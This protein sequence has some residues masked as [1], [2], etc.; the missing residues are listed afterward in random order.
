MMVRSISSAFAI[1]RHLAGSDAQGVTTIARAVQLSPSSCF[2]ILRTLVSEGL[3][4]FDARSRKYALEPLA[5]QYFASEPRINEMLQRING[6]LARVAQEFAITCSVW[7][8]SGNRLVLIEVIDSPSATRV[9]LAK[10]QRLPV[11]LGAMGRCIANAQGKSKE[12]IARLTSK[13]R[14][15][16]VPSPDA[17]WEGMKL[18][19]A[20][21]WAVDQD[22]Y[23]RGLTTLAAP[24]RTVEMAVRYSLTCVGF[25]GQY[26]AP[27][28]ERIGDRLAAIARDAERFW[29]KSTSPEE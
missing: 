14:W 5:A 11:Y 7:R 24:I 4:S 2:N 6:E 27:T 17:Y 20:R 3:L 13:L 18:A 15:Q 1:L 22:Y 23:I 19:G 21:G 26:D 29:H 12:D 28:L 16:S 10:G 8:L 25:S 9:H